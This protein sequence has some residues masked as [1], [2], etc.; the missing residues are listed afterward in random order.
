MKSEM[1]NEEKVIK[2]LEH[3]LLGV[4]SCHNGP[5]R[6]EDYCGNLLMKD[7]IAILKRRETVPVPTKY[8]RL[9][10]DACG[11]DVTPTQVYCAK[12]G[13]FINWEK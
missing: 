5:Y 10:C 13:C 2:G 9:R 4:N 8:G 1:T 7:T 11:A 3:H 12:C 6:D